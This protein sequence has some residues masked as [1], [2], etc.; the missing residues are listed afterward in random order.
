MNVLSSTQIKD[1]PKPYVQHI[2]LWSL[3]KVKP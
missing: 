3:E 1:G 2:T